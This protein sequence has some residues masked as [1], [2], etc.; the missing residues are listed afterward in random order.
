MDIGTDTDLIGSPATARQSG[1]HQRPSTVAAVLDVIRPRGG[2]LRILEA[3]DDGDS[4]AATSTPD[5]IV[6]VRDLGRNGD[7][8]R[9]E[10]KAF[11]CAVGTDLVHRLDP[12]E[13]RALL[14]RL[15]RAARSVVLV[16]SP[17]ATNG[18]NP[19]E[20][21]IEL[22]RELGDS[23]LVLSEE[24]LPALL[25]MRELE[26][27][28]DSD[29][30]SS[31]PNLETIAQHLLAPSPDPSRSV[32]ISIIDPDAPGVDVSALQWCCSAPGA[33]GRDP[34]G[35]AVLPL[36]LEVRRLSDRLEA[37]RVSGSRAEAEAGDLRGKVAE[38][39][40]I[41]SEDRAAREAADGLVEI[42]AAARGY[43]IGLALCRARAAFRRRAGSAWRF[44]T[45]PCRAAARRLRHAPPPAAGP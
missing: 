40:R 22:F 2:A 23:V 12:G 36:A 27:A 7:A 8:G 10:E 4:L 3:A 35:L 15:R 38:L 9:F 20:E 41:A 42:V 39:T 13:R 43:R 25:T 6:S 21:A 11:D 28:G 30:R 26:L 37:E 16:E 17:R 31:G 19:F 14:A 44:V 24:H 1:A 5:E 18:H 29:G 34:A 33:A 32:L 45:A